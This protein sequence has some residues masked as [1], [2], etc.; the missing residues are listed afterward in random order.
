MAPVSTPSTFALSDTDS[1]GKPPHGTGWTPLY[2][3]SCV[4]FSPAA[5][6]SPERSLVVKGVRFTGR[7]TKMT[8]QLALL[9]ATRRPKWGVGM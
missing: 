4:E 1:S 8:S 9:Q 3:V 2:V 6:K 5:L 7:D